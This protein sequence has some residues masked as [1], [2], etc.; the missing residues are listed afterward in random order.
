LE[1]LSKISQQA[2]LNIQEYL[3]GT[4]LDTVVG[5]IHVAVIQTLESNA[6]IEICGLVVAET[7]RGSGIGSQLVAR[8]ENWARDKGFSHIRVRTNILREETRKFYRKLGYQSRK[9][10]EVFDK[11]IDVGSLT[12]GSPI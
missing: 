12:R 8:A 1:Q 6:Y 11:L 5:W 10:Q 7:F 4:A 3:I 9:T 2:K